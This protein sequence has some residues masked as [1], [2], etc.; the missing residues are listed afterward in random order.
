MDDGT[1][2]DWRL[3]SPASWSLFLFSAR[4]RL[5][6]LS[7]LSTSHSLQSNV[8]TDWIRGVVLCPPKRR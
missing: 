4:L 6:T 1:G 5:A 8:R 7:S 2:R 3:T